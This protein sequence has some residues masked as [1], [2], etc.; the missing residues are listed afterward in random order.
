M[1]DQ[2]DAEAPAVDRVDKL[3]DRL[4]QILQEALSQ[5]R[6]LRERNEDG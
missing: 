5:A 1:T 4:E 3:L 2:D 6:Q